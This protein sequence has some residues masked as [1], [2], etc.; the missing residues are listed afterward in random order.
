MIGQQRTGSEPHGEPS[1]RGQDS[2]EAP[3]SPSPV[4]E[5]AELPEFSPSSEWY[6]GFGWHGWTGEEW[7]DWYED[8]WHDDS[9][10]GQYD[11][12]ETDAVQWDE[13]DGG[14]PEIL[15]E[16]VLGWLLMRRSGLS[17]Q[18]K[19]SI[20]AAAGNSLKFSDV[21]R[22]MRAQEEELLNQERNRHSTNKPHH[23]SF[24]IQDGDSWGLF[25]GGS[26]EVEGVDEERVH[27]LETEAF[28]ATVFPPETDITTLNSDAETAWYSD[29]WY[30]WVFYEDEWHASTND[31]FVAYSD[32]RPWLEAEE[33]LAVDPAAGKEIQDLYAAYD[34]RVRTFRE[35]RDL[36]HQKGKNRGYYRFHPKGKSK[37]KNP[38]KGK[39]G[40]ASAVLMNSSGKG[41]GQLPSVTKKPG[42]T[43][44]FICGDKNHDFRSCP[45]RGSSSAASGS[46]GKGRSIN[47]VDTAEIMMVEDGASPKSRTSV[48]HDD[49]QR[50]ILTAS[51]G[52]SQDPHRLG[53]A[54][55]DTGAT[56]TVGSLQAIEYIVNTRAA[57]FGPEDIGVDPTRTK[58][59]KFGN[60][61]ER[62]AESYIL[63]PQTVNG[64]PASLGVYTLDVP[65][66]PLL[67]GIRTMNKLGA[68]INVAERTLIFTKVF[69]GT[70][71]PLLRGQNGHLL[72]DLCKDW[73]REYQVTHVEHPLNHPVFHN[74]APCDSMENQ[75]APPVSQ[76]G[77]ET[78]LSDQCHHVHVVDTKSEQSME[79]EVGDHHVHVAHSLPAQDLAFDFESL[80]WSSSRRPWRR[81]FQRGAS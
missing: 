27:W 55:L 71:I 31:G 77:V 46:S 12:N 60:A 34:Q 48:G 30:D 8:S 73:S 56:E 47:Y 81:S 44:C 61:E 65:N 35:A 58:R 18:S 10:S 76:V 72:L 15:P 29:G 74:E 9:W 39:K 26:E 54:V 41:H 19:L 2:A 40:S 1:D 37:G 6:T 66:V 32:M 3:G 16:E 13:I 70:V 20:Q 62:M 75:E 49:L 21:E 69:P 78:E 80:S 25:M 33:A 38:S 43:G 24:W 22:A 36:V 63:L 67:I 50:L 64:I 53:Y 5:E 51:T 42:Y 4:G 17:S 59:F 57:R 23:R 14:L 11:D 7:G 28:A 79:S 52:S 45:K 68:V